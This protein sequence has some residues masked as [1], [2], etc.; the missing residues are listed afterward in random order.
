MAILVNQDTHV[1][2]QGITGTQGSYHAARMLEY[3]VKLVGGVVPGRGGRQVEGVPVFDTVAEACAAARVDASLVLVPPPFVLEAAA[4]AI[5]CG[6]PLVVV[7]TE[8]VPVLDSMRL[9]ALARQR[10]VRVVGPNTIGVISPGKSKVGIMPG[11]IYS[12]GPVGI[13]S[14]SGTLTHEVASNLTFRGIGQ[15]TCVGIGGDPIVGTTFVE[16]LELFR[17]DPET[18]AVV[19]I[20]E[21]GGGAEEEAAEYLRAG[22]P[23]PVLA[24][25][26]GQ[27]APPEK[28]MGHA[29]AIVQG[30]S[31]TAAAKMQ[32]LKEA[33]V[34]VAST[35]DGILDEVKAVLS[36]VA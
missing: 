12:P 10:G 17:H 34:R 1:I 6:I 33:G 27:T 3:N 8:H 31:G 29:G 30:S 26:A 35:L 9:V 21:I 5:E 36:H 23:K 20:G 28:R 14:R 24:F 15:S 32:R 4:E 22:Y 13:V 16:V 18:E 25:I 2:I 11:Y 19:L 7:I